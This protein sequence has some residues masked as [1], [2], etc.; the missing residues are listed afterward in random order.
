MYN[1]KDLIPW[2]LTSL[3]QKFNLNAHFNKFT[4]EFDYAEKKHRRFRLFKPKKEIKLKVSLLKNLYIDENAISIPKTLELLKEILGSKVIKIKIDSAFEFSLINVKY[5]GIAKNIEFTFYIES[6][7]ELYRAENLI[8]NSIDEKFKFKK[9][10]QILKDK[11]ILDFKIDKNTDLAELTF[12]DN[13]ILKAFNQWSFYSPYINIHTWSSGNITFKINTP[14]GK[15][16]ILDQKK[17]KNK[18]LRYLANELNFYR[19]YFEE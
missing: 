3:S 15:Q 4:C 5:V 12:E 16:Y 8:I 13:L 18:Y 19:R 1:T 14:Y 17:W 7:W 10:I 9:K 11:K 2:T 6:N